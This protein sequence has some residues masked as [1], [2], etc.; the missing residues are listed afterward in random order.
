MERP[1]V[2]SRKKAIEVMEENLRILKECSDSDTFLLLSHD[3]TNK[4]CLGRKRLDKQSGRK[5]MNESKTFVLSE[6]K[7]EDSVSILSIYTEKQLDILNIVPIG[8]KHDMILIPQL[9]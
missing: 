8:Q 5:L 7:D 1:V 3:L 9:E 6:D 4:R 2:I